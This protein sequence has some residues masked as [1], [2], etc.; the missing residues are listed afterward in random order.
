MKHKSIINAVLP[1]LLLRRVGMPNTSLD[2]HTTHEA[3]AIA[4]SI[5]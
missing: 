5:T 4:D 2:R 1:K 3:F